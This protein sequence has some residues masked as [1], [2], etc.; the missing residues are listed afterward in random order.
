MS[1]IVF[2]I[3][4]ALFAAIAYRV[5]ADMRSYL[6]LGASGLFMSISASAVTHFHFPREEAHDA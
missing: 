3:S 5:A 6:V 2:W 4:C 1:R